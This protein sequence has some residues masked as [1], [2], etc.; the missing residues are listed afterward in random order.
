MIGEEAL[1][2]AV[3][4]PSTQRPWA[5]VLNLTTVPG[6]RVR[7]AF[8]FTVTLFSITR[9]SVSP[10]AQLQ[11]TVP[12]MVEAPPITKPLTLLPLALLIL[13][14]F[15]VLAVGPALLDSLARLQLAP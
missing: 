9:G 8:S 3:S 4:V 14:G 5:G 6:S 1:P 2:S 15:V 10:P 7:L 11:V 13:P 12:L